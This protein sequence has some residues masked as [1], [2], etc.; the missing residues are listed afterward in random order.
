MAI[1][2]DKPVRMDDGVR[3]RGLSFRTLIVAALALLVVGIVGGGWAMSRMLTGKVYAGKAKVNMTVKALTLE[4]KTAETFRLTKLLTFNG[5]D[6]VPAAEVR[7]GDI[8]CVAGMEK[9]SVADTICDPA[10]NT[11]IESTPVDP[12]T[13]ANSNR[14]P[15][16][17]N[18]NS[19]WWDGSNIYGSSKEEQQI[20]R[21]GSGGKVI[22]FCHCVNLYMGNEKVYMTFQ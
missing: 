15:A 3:S 14:P 11:P 22:R 10:V 4:G 16:Y 7:A 18:K 20:L 5:I 13:V 21:T 9:T 19:H 12:P 8:I 17:V 1:E 2:N 6:R